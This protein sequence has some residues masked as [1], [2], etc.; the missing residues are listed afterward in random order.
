MS[1][2]IYDRLPTNIRKNYDDNIDTRRQTSHFVTNLRTRYLIQRRRYQHILRI[3]Q[4]RIHLVPARHKLLII[5]DF[6][7]KAGHD[8][9]LNIPKV[10]GRFAVGNMNDSGNNVSQFCSM[11]NL[12]IFNTIYQHKH[13]R[14]MNWT[15]PDVKNQNQ[16]DYIHT[17][18]NDEQ[19]V[20]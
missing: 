1:L 2:S 8:S 20:K 16:I 14:R 10:A 12:C 19:H 9:H 3:N 7:A 15:S 5:G 4:D 13:T 6:N 18:R 17:K 11:N